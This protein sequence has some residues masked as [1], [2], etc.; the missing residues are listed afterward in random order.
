[1]VSVV[2]QVTSLCPFALPGEAVKSKKNKELVWQKGCWE[3]LNTMKGLRSAVD[4]CH[5][6]PIHRQLPQR[7]D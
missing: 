6:R 3:R 5:S 1:M 2:F 4:L 7:C